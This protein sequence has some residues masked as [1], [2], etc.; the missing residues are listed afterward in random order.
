VPYHWQFASGPTIFIKNSF[1]DVGLSGQGDWTGQEASAFHRTKSAPAALALKPTNDEAEADTDEGSDGN[2]ADDER[3]GMCRG[4]APPSPWQAPLLPAKA[5]EP[6]DAAAQ[7]D[8]CPR[9]PGTALA[10][11]SV[12]SATCELDRAARQCGLAT[13]SSR[14][15]TLE[16]AVI[17]AGVGVA[18]SEDT[19][20]SSPSMGLFASGSTGEAMVGW[21]LLPA[22]AWP[23]PGEQAV[24]A[25]HD[26][27]L[28]NE[29][30]DAPW[31][32]ALRVPHG[33]PQVLPD[34]SRLPSPVMSPQMS[35]Q[36]SPVLSRRSSPQ[37]SPQM[38]PALPPQCELE[39]LEQQFDLRIEEQLGPPPATVC[40]SSYISPRFPLQVF[41][42]CSQP[43]LSGSSQRPG[44]PR[45]LPASQASSPQW[46]P[47]SPP[48]LSP[49]RSPTMRASLQQPHSVV[50]ELDA[51][52][53]VRRVLWSV[54]AG[55]LKGHERQT[56]SPSFE[57][58]LGSPVNFR[59]VIFPRPNLDGK[60][61]ASF[62]KSN[63]RG[64][65]LLKCEAC[66]GVVTFWMSIG[67]G[68]QEDP[69]N[70]PRGP[71]THDFARHST[72]GLPKSLEQWDFSSVVDESSN[73]FVVCLDI[74]PR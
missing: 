31:M 19:S 22:A 44:P 61:S 12:D 29:G 24:L 2:S 13:P 58:L 52:T 50:Q 25:H 18:H 63:G 26:H 42:G 30:G 8:R 6:G 23:S 71:V 35:C 55:K 17:S 72:C 16:P 14:A 47:S 15:A 32:A 41:A 39:E 7:V 37:L 51:S 59:L 67:N 60:G 5:K 70:Q 69:T 68:R 20:A 36:V 48:L 21:P 9:T 28:H 46:G 1:L 54:D 10:T 53:G 34:F 73:T 65:V 3:C 4:T 40:S 11:L 43:D 45:S 66:H 38:S 57:L 74:L 64:S 62:K 33:W 27:G 56:V 49:P